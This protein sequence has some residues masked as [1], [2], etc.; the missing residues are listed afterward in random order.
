MKTLCNQ[1]AATGMHV[2]DRAL[3]LRGGSVAL[4]LC[5]ATPSSRKPCPCKSRETVNRQ[6]PIPSAREREA[7]GHTGLKLGTRLGLRLSSLV[8]TTA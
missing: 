3:T 7:T 1:R 5:P 8:S 2:T 6:G 4:R